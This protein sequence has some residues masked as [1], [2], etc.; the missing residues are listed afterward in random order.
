VT[1]SP[2][3][4][5]D[6]QPIPFESDG[7]SWLVSWH[8]PTAEPAGQPHGASAF[9]VTSDASVVLISA[10]GERWGW[11]GGRPENDETWVETLRRE[12]LEE[13]CAV[14]REATLLG[15]TKSV[16][17][18]G[19]EA[20]LELVR[21]IWCAVVDVLPWDPRFEIPYR[22][23]VPIA[24]LEAHLSMERGLEPIYR[25]ALIEAGLRERS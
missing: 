16:C 14:V 18:R 19:D 3:I 11:P 17:V 24:E 25:R 21:S 4:A 20:G 8:L 23:I 15:F 22:R 2:A 9:C 5:G 10:D 12:M 1:D 6:E 13:A 7:Q